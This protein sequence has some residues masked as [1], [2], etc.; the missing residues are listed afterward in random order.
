MSGLEGIGA[1]GFSHGRRGSRPVAPNDQHRLRISLVDVADPAAETDRPTLCHRRVVQHQ[2]R[3]DGRCTRNFHDAGHCI[4]I[5]VIIRNRRRNRVAVRDHC[6]RI[7]VIIVR[8]TE[9]AAAT[10]FGDLGCR[11]RPVSPNNHSGMGIIDTRVGEHVCHR[12]LLTLHERRRGFQHQT[13]D[14]WQVRHRFAGRGLPGH[15]GA[16]RRRRGDRKRPNGLSRGVVEI[17][18]GHTE[19]A[20]TADVDD[21]SD[22]TRAIPP[23]DEN[24][25]QIMQ[26][27]ITDDT[28]QGD[29]ATLTDRRRAQHQFRHHGGHIEH[30]E[31]AVQRRSTPV[32]IR[33][34]RTD[35]LA[36]HHENRRVLIVQMT[37]GKGPAAIR[38]G[39]RGRRL[40]AIAPGDGGGM[41]VEHARI[42][43]T[44]GDDNRAALIDRGFAEHHA[45]DRR[46]QIIDDDARTRLAGRAI[47]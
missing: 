4:R 25:L 37:R 18:M 21:V 24:T 41:G 13:D 12:L 29:R 22:R 8:R 5:T 32:V 47:Q 14:R 40:R 7:I 44:A 15:A 45:G 2:I 42:G 39:H 30:I 27:R 36:V 10:K 23:V 9:L 46:R 20:A 17:C 43:E 3:H 11:L 33:H 6:G 19:C 31:R 28:R 38:F 1:V 35:R 16:R 26:I 34:D